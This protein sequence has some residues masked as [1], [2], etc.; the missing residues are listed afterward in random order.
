[1][2]LTARQRAK[3][4]RGE[5]ANQKGK[6]DKRGNRETGKPAKKHPSLRTLD[7]RRQT[8]DSSRLEAERRQLTVMF[9]DLVDSTAL[10][11]R[12]DPEELHEVVRKYQE[13]C[14]A[15]IHRFEGHIAQYL[16]DG[17]LVYFGYPVAHED[18]AQRA[19]AATGQEG[20]S[21]QAAGGGLRLVHRRV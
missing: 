4:A 10:S 12:L 9:C 13:F 20:R 17:V 2:P 18:G 11:A 7:A 21:P 5:K 19:V 16:G 6:K 8:L 1:M 14:A 15:A 3:R